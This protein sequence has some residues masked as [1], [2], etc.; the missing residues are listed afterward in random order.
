MRAMSSFANDC[1]YLKR[2]GR[3]VG[4]AIEAYCQCYSPQGLYIPSLAEFRRFCTGGEYHR[5]PVYRFET[6]ANDEEISGK[7]VST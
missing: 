4:Y 2:V 6:E 5:C 1:P 7:R 3:E